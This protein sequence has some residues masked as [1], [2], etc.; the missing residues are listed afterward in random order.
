MLRVGVL[1]QCLSHIQVLVEYTYY[2]FAHSAVVLSFPFVG[3]GTAVDSI[4]V[5]VGGVTVIVISLLF[6]P[7][8]LLDEIIC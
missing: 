7:G 6:P 3:L 4:V 1:S 2:H 8:G 5:V